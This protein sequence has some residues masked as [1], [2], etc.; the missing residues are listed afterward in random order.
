MYLAQNDSWYLERLT[1]LAVGLF[2]LTGVLLAWLVSPWW[3]ILPGLVGLNLTIFGLTGFCIGANIFYKLGA[4][5]RLQK[6]S[7]S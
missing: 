7:D 4:K 1:W 5:P 2:T 3:L 6:T